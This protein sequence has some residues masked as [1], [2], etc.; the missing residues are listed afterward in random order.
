[1]S[2]QKSLIDLEKDVAKTIFPLTTRFGQTCTVCGQ[3]HFLDEITIDYDIG[4]ICFGCLDGMK[5]VKKED[6]RWED[7]KDKMKERRN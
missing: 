3:F 6:E 2:K 5:K 7:I 4:W 1:M